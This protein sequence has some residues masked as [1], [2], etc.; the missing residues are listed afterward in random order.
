LV[1][2]KRLF[3]SMAAFLACDAA[4]FVTGAAMN[5]AGGFRI[6]DQSTQEPGAPALIAPR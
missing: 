2:T 4:S 3:V 1:H 6:R 5:V